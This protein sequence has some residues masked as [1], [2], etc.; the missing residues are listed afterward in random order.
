MGFGDLSMCGI[1]CESECFGVIWIRPAGKPG[2][3]EGE[4]ASRYM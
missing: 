1:W 4:V 3:E 2:G